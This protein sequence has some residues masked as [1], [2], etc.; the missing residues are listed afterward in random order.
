VIDGIGRTSD[1]LYNVSVL[2]HHEH[3]RCRVYPQDVGAT[4]TLAAAAAANTF[5]N[6]MQIVPITTIGFCYE[7][8]GL[9][10]EAADAATTYLVQLGFS[11][12]D[13]SDPTTA[14]ILGE[15]R[16]LLPSPV[17]KA[18]ELLDYYSQDCP[19]NAKL[20][21]RVKTA[22]VAADELEVSVVIIR[23]I[24][25]TNAIPYLTTWPWAV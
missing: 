8:V 13:G 25:I 17:N 18:T 11:T 16:T 15:R 7:V 6:W 22:S 10:I 3:S 9:V 5:G 4:I 14:Q 21:G 1:T 19:A 12:A 24:E 20:W 2:E 23:H